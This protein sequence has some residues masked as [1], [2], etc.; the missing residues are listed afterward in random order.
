M[1]IKKFEA[2]ELKNALEQ[3]RSELGEDALILETRNRPNGRIEVLAAHPHSAS[4]EPVAAPQSG[5]TSVSAHVADI[6]SRLPEEQV[7]AALGK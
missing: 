1:H 3:I 4:P 6:L 5:T 7:Q 2:S